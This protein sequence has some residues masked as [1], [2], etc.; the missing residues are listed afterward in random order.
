MRE[1]AITIDGIVKFKLQQNG[2]TVINLLKEVFIWL[3]RL[4]R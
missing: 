2:Q 3:G 1:L 4:Y